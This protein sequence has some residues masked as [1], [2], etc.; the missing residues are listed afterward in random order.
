[1]K[2]LV[3]AVLG[4][5]IDAKLSGT[6]HVGLIENIAAIQRI[7]AAELAI[8]ARQHV[9]FGR[10]LNGI[11]DEL[12]GPITIVGSVGQRIEIHHRL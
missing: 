1:M 11:V 9:V 7:L 10:W 6:H 4:G 2:V 8:N 5:A 3:A 12:A